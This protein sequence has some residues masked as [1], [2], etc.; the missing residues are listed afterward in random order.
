M[1]VK[2]GRGSKRALT[3]LPTRVTF[4]QT[5]VDRRIDRLWL[6]VQLRCA[7]LGLTQVQLAKR[8]G[9]RPSRLV[10]LLGRPTITRSAFFRIVKALGPGMGPKPWWEAPLK[11]PQISAAKVR[12]KLRRKIAVAPAK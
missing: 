10:A 6:R 7:E 5:T 2:R 12:E 9:V 8:L 11:V 1:P 3:A 4:T